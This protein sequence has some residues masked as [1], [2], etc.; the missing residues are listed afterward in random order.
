MRHQNTFTANFVL[1]PYAPSRRNPERVLSPDQASAVEDIKNRILDHFANKAPKEHLAL[2]LT[3]PAGTGKTTIVDALVKQLGDAAIFSYAAPTGKAAVRLAESVGQEAQT[4][5]QVIYGAPTELGRCPKCNKFSQELGVSQKEAKQAGGYKCPSCSARYPATSTFETKLG[6]AKADREKAAVTQG[7]RPVLI[8]DESSM[9]GPQIYDDLLEA[10][11]VTTPILFVG[12]REQLEP[13]LSSEEKSKYPGQIWGPDLASPTQNLTQIHRQAAGSPIINLATR[14]RLGK[15]AHSPFALDPGFAGS[16]DLVVRRGRALD[17]AKWIADMRKNRQDATVLA[18]TNKECA[19]VNREARKLLG[20]DEKSY[21]ESVAA[22][23]SDRLLVLRNN[24]GY[25]RMNG[26]VLVVNASFRGPVVEGQ[27]T[28]W[29]QFIDSPEWVL[30]ANS[31]YGQTSPQ[32]RQAAQNNIQFDFQAPLGSWISYVKSIAKSDENKAYGVKPVDTEYYDILAKAGTA[33]R[34]VAESAGLRDKKAKKTLA[35]YDEMAKIFAVPDAVEEIY[36]KTGMLA[37][38]LLFVDYGQC[39]TVHKSQGSQWN[40][41]ALLA[42]YAFHKA[43]EN[44]ASSES[45]RRWLY[46]AVTRAAKKLIVFAG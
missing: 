45:M 11:P 43:W 25:G 17:A 29:V 15:N 1:V 14:V 5:H 27:A 4:L 38:D 26:E 18:F 33:D 46:T 2:V 32:E 41:V 30:T 42:G 35:Q 22:V 12:D 28:T 44:P 21:E 6:F 19:D 7:P 36:A 8:V 31:L 10:T 9:I 23:R 37:A 16:T 3:G 20:L 24:R 39:L 40:Y 13:V 34:N